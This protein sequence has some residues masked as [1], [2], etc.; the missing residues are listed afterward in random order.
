MLMRVIEDTI[1]C[2]GMLM[3]VI[4]D[5]SS[6]L[7]LPLATSSPVL[8]DTDVSPSILNISPCISLIDHG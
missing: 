5:T 7:K 6:E 3:R 1:V 4:E 8:R 2:P